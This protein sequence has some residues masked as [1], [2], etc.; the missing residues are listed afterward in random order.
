MKRDS[1]FA[2]V[3]LRLHFPRS[4]QQ[5]IRQTSDA[6]AALQFKRRRQNYGR[7]FWNANFRRKTELWRHSARL[8]QQ[9]AHKFLINCQ[10]VLQ[11]QR[12]EF[13]FSRLCSLTAQATDV[14]FGL[15]PQPTV[16]PSSLEAANMNNLDNIGQTFQWAGQSYM[17]IMQPFAEKIFFGLVLIEIII[18]CV[19]FLTDQEEPTRLLAE[20][21]KKSLASRVSV[22][23]DRQCANVVQRDHPR[24][25]ANWWTGRRYSWSQPEL[26]FNNGLAMF[27]IDLSR[28]RESGMVS[29]NDR[30]SDCI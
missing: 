4:L 12:L 6:L 20:L 13:Q 28:L 26:R 11:P 15:Q 5:Q 9:P 21:V 8:L 29:R 1:S 23:D 22:C 18:T 3:G 14:P 7:P 25:P 24:L 19:H 30:I 2:V 16:K 27:Q 10:P 17:A